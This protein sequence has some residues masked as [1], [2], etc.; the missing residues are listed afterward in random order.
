MPY[1]EDVIALDSCS[2]WATHCSDWTNRC[3]QQTGAMVNA[4]NRSDTQELDRLRRLRQTKHEWWDPPLLGELT[5]P[6]VP[7]KA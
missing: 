2:D 7:P 4:K 6:K 3:P 1:T 5:A